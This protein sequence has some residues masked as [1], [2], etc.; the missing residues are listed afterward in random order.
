MMAA[1]SIRQPWAWLVVNG[2]RDIENRDWPTNFRGPLLV[3]AGLT[4]T[5]SDYEQAAQLLDEAGL[6]PPGGLPAYEALPRGGLVGWT[7]VV[8]YKP[9]VWLIWSGAGGLAVAAIAVLHLRQRRVDQLAPGLRREQPRIGAADPE[10][11]LDPVG[12]G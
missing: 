11:E 10:V 5:R 3:H 6:L 4:M 1:L 2:Y 12:A 9:P 7:R 8:E